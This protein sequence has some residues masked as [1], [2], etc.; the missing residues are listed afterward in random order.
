MYTSCVAACARAC[1]HTY[2]THMHKGLYGSSQAF[3]IFNKHSR[4][5]KW[6]MHGRPPD[7]VA[8]VVTR[9]KL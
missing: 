3:G 7:C 8:E 1:T 5:F 4:Q 9:G 6:S 2:V